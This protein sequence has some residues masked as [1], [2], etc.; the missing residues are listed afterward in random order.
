MLPR[1]SRMLAS[2]D[3]RTAIRR[4]RRIGSATMVMH[5]YSP[6]SAVGD[7]DRSDASKT[8]SGSSVQ[9]SAAVRVGFVVSKAVGN[10]VVRNRVKRRLRHLVAT[11][12]LAGSDLP[13]RTAIVIR[14]L[15]AASSRPDLL[16]ADFDRAWRRSFGDRPVFESDGVAGRSA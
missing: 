4:G 9:S 13:D 12:L 5:T 1:S 10:A 8:Q 15:P 7:T 2:N 16:V 6:V 11:A 14:A 3:F